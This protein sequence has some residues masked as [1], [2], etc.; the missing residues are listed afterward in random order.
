MS[1][2]DFY[3][4]YFHVGQTYQVRSLGDWDCIFS[5][6]VT[7]RTNKTVWI[8]DDSDGKILMRRVSYRGDVEVLKP[9]GTYSL[10]PTLRADR[11][12]A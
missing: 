9:Y 2:T 12:V 6:Q 5:F 7:D 11:K 8:K 1:N 4:T 3:D 10:S